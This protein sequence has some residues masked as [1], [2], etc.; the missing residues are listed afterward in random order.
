M[1]TL[2]YDMVNNNKRKGYGVFILGTATIFFGF[3]CVSKYLAGSDLFELKGLV[4][5]I[6]VG[7][8]V[9]M[10]S[11]WAFYRINDL[12]RQLRQRVT[13]LEK[14]LPICMHCKKIRL[15]NGEPTDQKAWETLESTRRMSSTFFHF[16]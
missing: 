6:S 1:L 10:F 5:P 11:G 13:N 16:F 12:N 15:P 7:S 4:I 14:L 8:I 3:S 9:G 2:L